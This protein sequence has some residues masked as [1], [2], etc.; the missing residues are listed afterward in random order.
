M[1]VH[2]LFLFASTIV[3]LRTILTKMPKAPK[4]KTTL[5][6]T[7]C[8]SQLCSLCSTRLTRNYFLFDFQVTNLEFRYCNESDCKHFRR[9]VVGYRNT[10]G[11]VSS[12]EEIQIPP[13]S[14]EKKEKRLVTKSQYASTLIQ[15]IIPSLKRDLFRCSSYLEKWNLQLKGI[16]EKIDKYQT[17]LFNEK[18]SE[19]SVYQRLLKILRYEEARHVEYIDR[20]E[21]RIVT[22]YREKEHLQKIL[23]K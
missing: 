21:L 19:I 12:E 13:E 8:R 17:P 10:G 4:K 5:W 6:D 3:I 7:S 22:L 9:K 20:V 16:Q 18:L 14:Q 1:L 23:N 2:I 11:K 15:Y